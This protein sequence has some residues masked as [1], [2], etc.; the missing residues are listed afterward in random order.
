MRRYCSLL[1]S[2]SVTSRRSQLS[3]QGFN[4]PLLLFWKLQQAEP[5]G[6][7]IRGDAVPSSELNTGK[8][9]P[10]HLCLQFPGEYER[11]PVRASA[12][13]GNVRTEGFQGDRSP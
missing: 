5:L 7:P 12:G 13:Y 9:M 4:L 11:I 6:D 10:E 8:V 3:P 2:L 1:N